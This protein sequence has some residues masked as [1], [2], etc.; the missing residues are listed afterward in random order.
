MIRAFYNSAFGIF[1]FAFAFAMPGV[2]NATDGAD[3]LK[4]GESAYY[5]GKF[6]DARAA[7]TS[8]LATLP[9]N[10]SKAFANILFGMVELATSKPDA[11]DERFSDAIR[12]D[13]KR[14]LSK[15]K[16]PPNVVAQYDRVRARLI[17]SVQIATDP[18]DAQVSIDGVLVGITPVVVD[19]L[20]A[21]LHSIKFEKEGYRTE[22]REL[23]VRESVRPE[24][25][26]ELSIID[27]IFAIIAHRPI[28]NAT[29]GRSLRIKARVTDNQG[30]SSVT[31]KFRK[32][33]QGEYKDV[34]MEQL[35]KNVYEGVITRDEIKAPLIEYY[36]TATDLGENV[37]TDG[38]ADT[39]FV[40]RVA[41]LDRDPPTIFHTPILATSDASRQII[42]AK[43]KDNKQVVGVKIFYKKAGDEFYIEEGMVLSKATGDYEAQLPVNILTGIKIAYYIEAVDSSGNVQFSGRSVSPHDVLVYRVLPYKSGYIVERKKKKNGKNTKDV[44]INVGSL[45]GFAKG[46]VFTVFNAKEKIIDPETGMILAINQMLTGKVE[47]TRAG[48][49]SSSAKIVKEFGDDVLEAGDL[50]RFRPGPPMSVGGRSEKFREIIVTWDV[51]PEPEVKG[52]L[53]Y[54]SDNPD[55]PFVL[56]AKKSGR[57]NVKT[58]DKGKKGPKIVDGKKYYY[59][60]V[61]Y[62][63]EKEES[64]MSYV[65]FV[66]AKGGPDPPQNI[67][68]SSGEIREVSLTWQKSGDKETTGYHITRSDSVDGEYKKIKDITSS[69][70]S[71]YT[72]EPDEESKHELVDGKNYW[73]RIVSYNRQGKFGNPTEPV[74][75]VTRQR[76]KTPTG[77]KVVSSSVRSISLTWEMN[78]DPDIRRYR[79]YRH[80]SSAGVFSMV[81]EIRD[82]TAT[83][84]TDSDKSGDKMKDGATYYYRI[85]AVNSGGADSKLSDSVN[86]TTFGPPAPPQSVSV[87]SGQVKQVTISWSLSPDPSVSGYSVYRSGGAA[88]ANSRGEGDNGGSDTAKMTL[89]KKIRGKTATKFKDTG[90]W[91]EPLSDGTSYYYIVR[92]FNNVGVESVEDKVI[93]AMTKPGPTQPSGLSSGKRR[94][95]A[96]SISWF[97]NSETDIASYRVLRSDTPDG[98]FKIVAPA[99]MDIRH[100]D[101]GLKNGATYFYRI[102]ALDKEGL[103]SVESETVSAETTPAPKAPVG[104]EA[105]ADSTSVTLTWEPDSETKIDHYTIYSM[106]FFGRE[107]VGKATGTEFTV[108]KLSKGSSYTYIVTATDS[109]GLVSEPSDPINATTD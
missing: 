45:K 22:E 95:G 63:S 28:T 35:E 14:K 16:Y 107:K 1:V 38:N 7:L 37:S 4:K 43:V 91:N 3:Q 75:A 19:D 26:L 23:V 6:A 103:L 83:E 94:A 99:V 81:K 82:R 18:A 61:A 65:G 11:A 20:L 77:L 76:P 58:K 5:Q 72:D 102:Q 53:V 97:P 55:G 8:A 69:D 31:L 25:F 54:R 50:I 84:Y 32:A 68:A 104:L 101:S 106:G 87:V 9:D 90:S 42:K 51:S 86:G 88:T 48:P 10:K 108:K 27:E 40:V 57:E 89:V 13:P 74:M 30:V 98:K 70:K 73:Y 71:R 39:P 44:T 15:K 52:Y 21:G 80:T 67:A 29:E 62:N 12:L 100:V 105:T 92:S 79:I 47:I 17:G 93:E 66:V 34:R 64:D 24:L 60:V 33:G 49:V 46:Q 78:T 41:E 2:S 96:V 109:E 56:F 36:L 59:K 85:K